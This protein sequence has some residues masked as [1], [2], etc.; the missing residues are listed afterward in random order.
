M[1]FI[2]L[3]FIEAAKVTLVT[4]G[5]SHAGF[6]FELINKGANA[7]GFF[8]GTGRQDPGRAVARDF[9]VARLES[10]T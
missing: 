1:S 8:H 10:G 4:R 2:V 3:S 7:V 9:F 6:G 5:H